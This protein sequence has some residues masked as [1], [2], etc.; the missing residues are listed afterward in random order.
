[1]SNA[2]EHPALRDAVRRAGGLPSGVRLL[3]F[4]STLLRGEGRDLDLLIV[5]DAAQRAA[6][7]TLRRSL[8]LD[9]ALGLLDIT[10]LSEAEEAVS[11]FATRVGA[12][13]VSYH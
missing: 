6:A 13:P 5:Y 7:L 2:F 11:S 3:A 12:R 10:M 4:G 9:S 8:L 1:M